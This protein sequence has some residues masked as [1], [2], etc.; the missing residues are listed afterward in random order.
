M[1]KKG[2]PSPGV[3]ERRHPYLPLHNAFDIPSD[4]LETSLERRFAKRKQLVEI[5]TMAVLGSRSELEE[6][7]EVHWSRTD[8]CF[9]MSAITIPY[10][11]EGHHG[12]IGGDKTQTS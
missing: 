12:S 9:P 8:G 2:L 10:N 7:V 6:H 1:N 4:Y 11:L 5:S 3:Q